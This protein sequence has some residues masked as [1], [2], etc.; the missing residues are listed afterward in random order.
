[1]SVDAQNALAVLHLADEL[2]PLGKPK[3][4]GPPGDGTR[5]AGPRRRERRSRACRPE[6]G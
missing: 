5:P 3:L 6:P 1:M 2:D 4:G